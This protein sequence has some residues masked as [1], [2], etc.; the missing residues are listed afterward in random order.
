MKYLTLLVMAFCCSA[1]ATHTEGGKKKCAE[2]LS[3]KSITDAS[4]TGLL[5]PN[6]QVKIDEVYYPC[7]SVERNQIIVVQ[8]RPFKAAVFR[9][10]RG[11][12]GDKF[13]TIAGADANTYNLEINGVVLKT[14]K[15]EPYMIGKIGYDIL[16]PIEQSYHGILPPENFLVFGTQKEGQEDSTEFGPVVLEQ[17]KGRV[18]ITK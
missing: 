7:H 8:K 9:V 16:K 3:F 1:Q 15:G 14:P 6:Q 2:K 4:M 17:I 5:D 11:M 12:P 10:V 18:Y 13:K